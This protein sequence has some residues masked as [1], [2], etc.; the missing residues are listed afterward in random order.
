[1]IKRLTLLALIVLPVI[2]NA[3]PPR[4]INWPDLLPPEAEL[5]DPLADVSMEVRYDLGYAAQVLSDEQE[6]MITQNGAE[7]RNAQATLDRLEANG[8]DTDTLVKAI[9]LH[10][11]EIERRGKAMRDDLNG[12]LVRIPGYALPLE[13]SELGVTELL[14]VPYV[15]ACIHTPPPPA[16]QIVYV[17]A[18]KPIQLEGLYEPVWITGHVE[19]QEGSRSLSFIDGQADVATGYTIKEAQIE[20]YE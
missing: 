16:N 5:S 19:T 13:S 11:A 10:D 17:T 4:T 7:Y 8:I 18:T 12:E 14:L 20:P 6:G 2:A 3:A 9:T 1:M 15:G